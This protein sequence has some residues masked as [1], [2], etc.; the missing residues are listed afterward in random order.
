MSHSYAKKLTDTNVM[1]ELITGFDSQQW[2]WYDFFSSLPRP[3]RLRGPPILI[4]NGYRGLLLW[5]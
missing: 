2:Q 5:G 4:S 1:L 3:D